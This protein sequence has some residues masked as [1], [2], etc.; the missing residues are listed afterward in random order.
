MRYRPIVW[1]LALMLLLVGA[2]GVLLGML[3]HEPAFYR[4]QAVA[5]GPERQQRSSEFKAEL[6]QCLDGLVNQPR[7]GWYARFTDVQINSYLEEDGEHECVLKLPEGVAGPRVALEADRL[8]VGFRHGTG[9]FSSVVSLDLRVWLAPR[10]A[11][12]VAIEVLGLRRGAISVSTHPL[13]DRVAEIA[14]QRGLDVTWFRHNGRPV[15]L[16][17]V[18]SDQPR[19]TVLLQRLEF[20]PATLLISG[21]GTEGNG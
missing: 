13:L 8:R 21:S 11:N 3:R 20:Q 9:F 17:R 18:Q 2:A 10:E 19:P 15:A 7:Q 16:L 5:A 12:A 14:R 4:R 1:G 6:S